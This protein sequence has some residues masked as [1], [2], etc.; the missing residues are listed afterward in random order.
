MDAYLSSF[1]E[2]GDY[3]SPE[4]KKFT[5]FPAGTV[6]NV[7]SF[8]RYNTKFGTTVVAITDEFKLNLPRR[9]DNLFN[10][11]VKL[12]QWNSYSGLKITY[13]GVKNKAIIISIE[14]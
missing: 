4:F 12:K 1:N 10:T 3:Q 6:F 5:D 14:P 11:D 13:H 9:F 7:N 2:L 8:S